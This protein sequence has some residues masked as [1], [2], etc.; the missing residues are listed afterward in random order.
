MPLHSRAAEARAVDA[1]TAYLYLKPTGDHCVTGHDQCYVTRT[2]VRIALIGIVGGNKPI[3]F[4][5]DSLSRGNKA[6][7]WPRACS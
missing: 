4:G 5:E 7:L 3:R 6:A 1:A 2:S